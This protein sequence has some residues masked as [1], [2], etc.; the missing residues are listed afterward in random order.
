MQCEATRLGVDVRGHGNHGGVPTYR[1]T[2]V[3]P[4]QRTRPI[5]YPSADVLVA[6]QRVWANGV[7]LIVERVVKN[8]PGDQGPELVLCRLATS[9]EGGR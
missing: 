6:G 5:D 7:G 8:K 2:Y 9:V 3:V 1:L 4:G